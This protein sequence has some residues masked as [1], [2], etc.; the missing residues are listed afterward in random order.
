VPA[1]PA[2]VLGLVAA[3]NAEGC[4]SLAP[5]F[6]GGFGG[7]GSGGG[8]AAGRLAALAASLPGR[9]AAVAA[10]L[11]GWPR[12]GP[13][14]Y[15][16]AAM[17]AAL[18]WF[19]LVLALH[20]LLPGTYAQGAPLPDGSGRTLRYKLNASSCF[21]VLYGSALALSAGG[22]GGASFDLG[23]AADNFLPLA[24][25]SVL[26]STALSVAV[27]AASFLPPGEGGTEALNGGSAGATAAA[28]AAGGG[29]T[30][31]AAKTN[32]AGANHDG[33][34]PPRRQQRRLLSAHGATGVPWY[35]FWM[36][37]ELN[38]RV[39][40]SFPPAWVSRCSLFPAPFR[41]WA[42]RTSAK[43]SADLDLKEF[44][45]LYPGMMGWAL[46][47][48]S[49]ACAQAR[50]HPGAGFLGTGVSNAML[51]VNAFELWYVADALLNEG[52]ILTTM[53]VTT[54]G[55]GFMLSFGDL[56]WVPFTF[57]TQA[58][59][60]AES[61]GPPDGAQA[62]SGAAALGVLAVQLGGYAIFRGANGQKN[63]FRRDPSAPAVARL[64]SMPTARGTRLL[65]SGWWGLARHVNYL[66]DWIMGLAWCL[67]TG[68]PG[69]RAAVPYFYA[70]YFAL[71]LAHRERRDDAACAAK[72]GA[73]DWGRYCAL[74]PWRIVP[75]VY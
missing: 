36:G 74:V 45:E 47:N 55:L 35:D 52:A 7:G 28:S 21:V 10:S 4:L 44:C 61:A 48:L 51:L 41:R 19:A 65:V 67:P 24:T 3:C 62:L 42:A 56:A 38:P 17:A 75:W 12:R 1:L 18:G 8:G 50:D 57:A 58:R 25:A 71:L 66:G 23:W 30:A 49:F 33:P 5:L 6:S 70:A 69:L 27:Y 64:R 15:T 2:V 22:L 72:Y 26:L 29:A 37:R 53:D 73:A 13:P 11:P 63:A 59:F 43:I 16:H 68:I 39:R 34:P 46:L 14:L 54:D 40:L 60:L 20:L 9:L 31:V 32:A